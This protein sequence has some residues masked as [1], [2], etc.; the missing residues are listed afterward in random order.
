MSETPG[1]KGLVYKMSKTTIR[2]TERLKHRRSKDELYDELKAKFLAQQ[3]SRPSLR[4]RGRRRLTLGAGGGT[5]AAEGPG[6]VS[7]GD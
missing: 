5:E 2:A 6:Q 1:R 3:A 4:G 7:Q